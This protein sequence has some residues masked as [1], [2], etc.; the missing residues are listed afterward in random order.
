LEIA[1]A[2]QADCLYLHLCHPVRLNSSLSAFY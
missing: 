2:G 1:Q